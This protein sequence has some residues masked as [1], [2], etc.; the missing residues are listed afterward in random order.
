MRLKKMN[1]SIIGAIVF[2]SAC[3]QNNF[4]G[5][6]AAGGKKSQS[7][8]TATPDP[9]PTVETPDPILVE[10]GSIVVANVDFLG[11]DKTLMFR[12]TRGANLRSMTVGIPLNNADTAVLKNSKGLLVASGLRTGA[13]FNDWGF[14]AKSVSPLVTTEVFQE[15]PISCEAN[16]IVV[17]LPDRG[18]DA[19]PGDI[20]VVRG[21]QNRFVCAK[22]SDKYV[23][24]SRVEIPYTHAYSLS[25]NCPDESV[26]IA[27]NCGSC[28]V[29]TPAK[30][31]CAKVTLAP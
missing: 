5:G 1:L 7:A 20:S 25:V 17:G 21:W 19:V 4:A 13:N 8:A 2:G 15:R 12:G 18:V 29:P 28:G 11:A 24:S 27:Y 16:E 14:Y 22:I 26:M 23:L 6:H 10:G 31:T 30:L 3:S 9:A